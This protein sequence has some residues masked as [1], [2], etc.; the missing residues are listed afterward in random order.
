MSAPSST[1]D[2]IRASSA[3]GNPSLRHYVRIV[4]LLVCVV[5]LLTGCRS[6]TTEGTQPRTLTVSAAADLTPAFQ[7]LG[8]E[9]ERQEGTKV[10]FNFG[11]TGQLAQQIEQGAPVDLFA[12]ANVSFIEGL[13]Q[14][15]LIV[16]GTKQL[17]AQGRIT[18]WTRDDSPVKLERVE[19]LARP[20]FKRVAIANPEHAPYGVAAREA[21]QA[22]GVWETVSQ[23]LVY[24]ENISQT[25]Q[26][27][28]SGNVDA[29]IVALSLSTQSK[30]R[31]V[32][33]PA[34]LHK[35]LNQAL[36]VIKGA[37]QE[38]EARRFAAFVNSAQGRAVMRRYGFVLP[39][40]E[41]VQ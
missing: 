11:S 40:E 21:L 39:G 30:G 8:K 38:Q 35:P 37:Q 34:E 29:A 4:S 13:E 9:F 31:W 22:A 17:Y 18:L 6:E 24:G 28:E 7:A 16:P 36:A 27:A 33:I 1:P 2:T 23:K 41:P 3:D 19:D 5:A 10:I 14:K 20:E 26:Y 12:A 25:L 32:L 15:S